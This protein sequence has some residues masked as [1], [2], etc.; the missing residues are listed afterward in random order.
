M[1]RVSIA[2]T[3]A[4]FL[5]RDHFVHIYEALDRSPRRYALTLFDG[6]VFLELD[7]NLGPSIHISSGCVGEEQKCHLSVPVTIS[8]SLSIFE[9]HQF[10][11]YFVALVN[12]CDSFGRDA[13]LVFRLLDSRLSVATG[14]IDT[15]SSIISSVGRIKGHLMRMN[16]MGD[17]VEQ[18]LTLSFAQPQDDI[19]RLRI[20]L[21]G[22]VRYVAVDDRA[23]D[24][25]VALLSQPHDSDG[26][27]L[28]PGVSLAD[29]RKTMKHRKEI[30]RMLDA[31]NRHSGNLNQ[32]LE[33]RRVSR[34]R[35]EL[36]RRVLPGIY[37]T[38][39][40]VPAPR[41]WTAKE[42]RAL[43]TR[44]NQ[45]TGNL[46]DFCTLEGVSVK[47]FRGCVA[48]FPGIYVN[49][50]GP[51]P[52]AIS[53]DLETVRVLLAAP[54]HAGGRNTATVQLAALDYVLTRSDF[55]QFSTFRQDL[56]RTLPKVRGLKIGRKSVHRRFFQPLILCS[57]LV[58]QA[59]ADSYEAGANAEY[60]FNFLR[61][62]LE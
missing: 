30:E 6:T 49:R 60:A 4:E 25:W 32:F 42:K 45:R 26:P 1:Q 51:K 17:E 3:R 40:A 12:L 14:M 50:Y 11:V 8:S 36:Y 15:L 48:E 59:E 43:L 37:R 16:A 52:L 41:E 55:I 21:N 62:E 10:L 38:G 47:M 28:P 57:A 9:F 24:E 31:A 5:S 53:Y 23:G 13:G 7:F 46:P 54:D 19:D 61:D 29:Y 27:V 2:M 44:A 35:F 22:V 18:E 56:V 20:A 39:G 34:R 33:S 58:Y